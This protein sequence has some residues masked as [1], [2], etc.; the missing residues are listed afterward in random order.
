M[1]EKIQAP[2]TPEQVKALNKYQRSGAFHPF[3]CCSHNDC[4]RQARANQ[5]V[6]VAFEEGWTCPCGAWK[7]DWAHAFMAE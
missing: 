7:Q 5:G 2:F 3:T 4:D 6:L 1:L